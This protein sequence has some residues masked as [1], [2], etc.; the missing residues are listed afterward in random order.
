MIVTPLSS[1]VRTFGFKPDA[2]VEGGQ[3]DPAG[4]EGIFKQMMKEFGFKYVVS[5]LRESYS[6]TLTAG[7]P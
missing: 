2:D 4:Y 7:R 1:A 5:T 6:A 3:T